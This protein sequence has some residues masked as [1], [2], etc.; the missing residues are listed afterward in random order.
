LRARKKEKQQKKERSQGQ[1]LQSE[2]RGGEM[3]SDKAV[4][5]NKNS[6]WRR[7]PDDTETVL[8]IMTEWDRFKKPFNRVFLTLPDMPTFEVLPNKSGDIL[9]TPD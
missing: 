6:R 5:Y 8:R 2:R 4:Y 7:V 1:I 3:L 9:L